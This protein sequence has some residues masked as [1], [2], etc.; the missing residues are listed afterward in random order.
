MQAQLAAGTT[1]KFSV[2]LADY[3]AADGWA[4]AYRLAPRTAGTPIDITST[5][6]GTDHLVNVAKATT[7]AWAPGTYTVAAWVDN[8]TDRFDVASESGE[9]VI[10]PNPATLAGGADQRS[11]AEI[12]LDKVQ[13]LLQGKAGSGVMEYQING[14]Q[15]RSYSLPDLLRFESKLKTDVDRERVA[16]GKAPIYGGNRLQTIRV[17]M[18]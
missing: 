3:S 7:A 8:G 11:Q 12:A 17:R 2:T 1:L 15:L 16:A 14:R 18:A 13:A 4:L 9:I 6:S 5:A 10:T